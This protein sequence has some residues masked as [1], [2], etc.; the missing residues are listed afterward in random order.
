MTYIDFVRAG[1][2]LPSI[3]D[4]LTGQIYLG[5]EAFVQRM[6][7]LAK[8]NPTHLKCPVRSVAR[9]LFPYHGM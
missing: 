7:T 2:G 9:K 6:A 1:V 3:W 4:H 5:G 8:E